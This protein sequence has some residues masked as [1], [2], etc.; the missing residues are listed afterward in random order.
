[1]RGKPWKQAMTFSGRRGHHVKIDLGRGFSAQIDPED[2]FII[3]AHS[4][5]AMTLKTGECEVY[6]YAQTK[7]KNKTILMHRL[8]ADPERKQVVDHKN[9]DGLDNRKANLRV[10]SHS[11]NMQ[12]KRLYR[13]NKSGRKGVYKVPCSAGNSVRWRSEINVNKRRV[14]LGTYETLDAASA[15]YEEASKRLHG[16][17]RRAQ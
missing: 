9:G 12:N 2:L 13:N 7:I 3:V 6:H 8:I 4:W 11:Q 17:F 16:E 10:C 15:A 14:R 1:M 5:T